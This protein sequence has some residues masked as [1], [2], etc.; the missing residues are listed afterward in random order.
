MCPT[1]PQTLDPN[2]FLSV[3][4]WWTL[5]TSSYFLL[6]YIFPIYALQKQT[7]L[8]VLQARK[9]KVFLRRNFIRKQ[10]GTWRSAD[11]KTLDAARRTEEQK[12]ESSFA[13]FTRLCW[14]HYP[15]RPGNDL[16]SSGG[17][18][19]HDE[20]SGH[21]GLSS[22]TASVMRFCAAMV[23][24]KSIWIARHLWKHSDRS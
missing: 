7:N 23:T 14:L 8:E 18:G 22:C 10:S 12:Q 6:I 21:L 15:F 5:Y 1:E 16:D 24:S 3:L 9:R 11:T 4:L 2:P 19:W 17:A 13:P 20:T